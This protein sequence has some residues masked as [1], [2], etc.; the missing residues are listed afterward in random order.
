MIPAGPASTALQLPSSTNCKCSSEQFL[1]FLS[2]SFSI[3]SSCCR[4]APIHFEI[5]MHAS[6]HAGSWRETCHY[7]GSARGPACSNVLMNMDHTDDTVLSLL[8][9]I[10]PRNCRS[11]MCDLSYFHLN[12]PYKNKSHDIYSTKKNSEADKTNIDCVLLINCISKKIAL[13][14]LL[15]I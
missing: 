15:R 8:F 5:G 1:P 12:Q 11:P 10:H 3:M 14:I 2:A 9:A 6:E 13:I 4:L 7:S